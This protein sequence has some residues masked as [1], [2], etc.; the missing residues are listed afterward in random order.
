MEYILYH[1]SCPKCKILEDKLKL[2]NINYESITDVDIILAEGIKS[3]PVL[4]V[5][6]QHLSFAEAIKLL[7]NKL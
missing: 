6:N 2:K 7:N 3:V 1:T 5:N 4:K